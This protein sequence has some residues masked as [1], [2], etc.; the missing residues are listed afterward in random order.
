MLKAPPNTQPSHAGSAVQLNHAVEV[1]LHMGVFGDN[2][3]VSVSS[4][5]VKVEVPPGG[6]LVAPT[7]CC[8]ASTAR[9]PP[10]RGCLLAAL[11]RPQVRALLADGGGTT[12]LLESQAPLRVC[13][14]PRAGGQGSAGASQAPAA[15][16]APSLSQP[17]PFW[18]PQTVHGPTA[19]EVGSAPPLPADALRA[20]ALQG[21]FAA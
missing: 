12:R 21:A 10:M 17:P 14:P 13:I 5:S 6:L 1:T 19:W 15:G 11:P 4:L 20:G 16:Q 18:R 7:G 2:V 8:G 3:R 9:C